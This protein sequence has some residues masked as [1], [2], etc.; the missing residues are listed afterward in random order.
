MSIRAAIVGTA[1]I[2][3][4][5]PNAIPGSSTAPVVC[6]LAFDTQSSFSSPPPRAEY[7][8]SL[9]PASYR[10]NETICDRTICR[11]A[12]GSTSGRH[13]QAPLNRYGAEERI[14][15]RRL[16]AIQT[17]LL[18][19]ILSPSRRGEETK[20]PPRTSLFYPLETSRS[21][22]NREYPGRRIRSATLPNALPIPHLEPGR[23][24]AA[25]YGSQDGRRHG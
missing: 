3:P 11:Q 22:V 16:F 18:T 17:E 13:F 5:L 9:L 4:A 10:H 14:E 6:A 7:L 15:V 25:L 12:A 1:G 19:L 21:P 20:K 23:Q 24:D 2:L 8:F